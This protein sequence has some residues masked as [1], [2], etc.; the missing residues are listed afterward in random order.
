MKIL[1]TAILTFLL[2]ITLHTST[3]AAGQTVQDGSEGAGGN[4]GQAESEAFH[5]ALA[6]AQR[7]G[8]GAVTAYQL[9][10]RTL[11]VL[12]HTA[13][14]RLLLWYA[15]AV[16]L[17]PEAES[18]NGIEIGRL[19]VSFEKHGDRIMVRDHTSGLGKRAGQATREDAQP[20]YNKPQLLPIQVAVN[21]FSKGPVIAVFPI[22]VQD[23]DGNV[24][25]DITKTFSN[26]IESLSAKYH[27]MSTG[28]SPGVVDPNRSYISRIKVFNNDVDIRSHLTFLATDPDD[29][30]QTIQPKSIEV[31]HSFVIL[32]EKPMAA[33]TFDSRV[34]YFSSEY[35]EYESSSGATVEKQEVILRW[36][37]EK[38]DPAAEVSTP[39]KPILFYIGREVPQRWRQ[40]IKA[41]V[42]QWQPVFEAAGFKN[43]IIARDAPTEEEDPDWSAEDGRHSVI[44]WVA[45]S[46]ANAIGPSIYDPRS[47]EILA[48]H[49]QIW[50]EVLGMFERYYYSVV[51]SLDPNAGKLPMSDSKRGELLQYIVAHEVGHAIG[52]RHNHLASTT[53]SV[54]ELRDPNFANVHGPNSSIMAYG[55]FNQVAQPGDGVT[56]FLP[57]LGPYDYFAIKWGYGVHGKTPEEERG[58]L[59]RMALQSEGD[60]NLIWAAGEMP[61]EREIWIN[62]PRLQKENTGAE[63]IESTRLAIANLLRSLELLPQAAGDD[64]K[65]FRKTILE[66]I[67]QHTTFLESVA[68][69]VGGTINQPMS[70][71]GP[72]YRLVEKEKQQEA[73]V[74]LLGDGVMSL[75]PYKDP[76]IITRIPP[77]GGIRA[78]EKRQSDL[79]DTIFSG[80]VLAKLD[81]QQALYP[82][83]YGPI[84]LAEDIYHAIWSDLS[85]A[86]RWRRALQARFLVTCQVILQSQV[87]SNNNELNAIALMYQG[88]SKSYSRLAVASGAKT[89]FPAWARNSLMEL[90]ERL[91][92]AVQSASTSSDRYH[93]QTMLWRIGQII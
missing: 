86:P 93:F 58:M 53:Y 79:L 69:L 45:Q 91:E 76:I 20:S 38:S 42:E 63:R 59:E 19:V 31:G 78:I 17:P 32:P 11:F 61:K 48:A 2:L 60:R 64:I 68:T 40:Y 29:S 51:G 49:I 9:G 37:L 21:D 80:A 67:T 89:N 47:G 36:R 82:A 41:G 14:D 26:D 43:A 12:P 46:W 27:I 72:G 44:R 22:L 56:R 50:P 71:D 81:E 24:L 62:D 92:A 30:S 84:E 25:V 77:I 23:A 4:P 83:A 6:S 33:R 55:R 34:G 10:D 65:V 74:Y 18:V 90:Q 54:K 13:I 73:V 16:S 66:M 35:M 87:N 28:L 88:H 3:L 70:T 39:V 85:T 5:D 52:L 57:I 15:E 8:N 75:E 1:I 7:I